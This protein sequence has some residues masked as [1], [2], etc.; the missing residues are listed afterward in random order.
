MVPTVIVNKLTVVHK[1]SDGYVVVT[2]DTY[3]FDPPPG[4]G[5]TAPARPKAPP[6]RL[7]GPEPR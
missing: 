5:T 3:P 6:H 4:W 1:K 2:P 7:A